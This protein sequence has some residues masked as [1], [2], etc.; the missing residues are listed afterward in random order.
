MALDRILS[1]ILRA[2]ELAFAAIV[3]GIVGHYLDNSEAS[4]W[5]N[6]RHIYTIVVAALAMLLSLLWLLPFSSAFIHW[7]VDLFISILWFVAFGLL[8]DLIGNGCGG[9]F[10]WGNVTV[11]GDDACGRM[12]AVVAFSFLSAICWLASA[13]IGFFWTRRRTTTTHSR[14]ADGRR[15]W[16]RSRV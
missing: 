14:P 16:Y 2:A 12:K 5:D 3:A 1:F 6:G 7:P 10:N 15:T 11:T 9:V 8:V 13:I 4:A